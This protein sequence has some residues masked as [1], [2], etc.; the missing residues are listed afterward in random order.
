LDVAL[1]QDEYLTIWRGFHIA[2][3]PFRHVD[4][5]AV[6]DVGDGLHVINPA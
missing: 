1:K 3:L 4:A 5:Q 2:M 6:Q